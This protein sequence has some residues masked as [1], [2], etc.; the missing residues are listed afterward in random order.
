MAIELYYTLASD[1]RPRRWRDPYVSCRGSIAT[2]LRF[3]WYMERKY[4]PSLPPLYPTDRERDYNSRWSRTVFLKDDEEHPMQEVWDLQL[5]PSVT[6]AE[7]LTMQSMMDKSYFYVV[8]FPKVAEAW[9][10]VARMMKDDDV[11]KSFCG[12]VNITRQLIHD[13][14]GIC[15]IA[16]HWNSVVNFY[17]CNG[18]TDKDCH[19]FVADNNKV[20]DNFNSKQHGRR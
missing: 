5:S 9:L 7:R 17:E 8:D 2:W 14:P 18:K 16:I 10:E 13:T 15:S 20:E 11:E 1:K 12:L 3:M 4:L 19:D 6:H